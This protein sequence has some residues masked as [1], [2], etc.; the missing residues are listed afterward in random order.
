MKAIVC[1][2]HGGIDKLVYDDVVE[3][4][5]G[6]GEVVVTVKIAGLNFFDTL[7]IAG[8]YQYKPPL[9]FSPGAEGAGVICAVGEGVSDFRVGDRVAAFLNNF[10]REKTAVPV[11]R[12]LPIPADITDEEAAALVVTYG[13]SLHAL[14]DRASLQ[15]GETLAVLGATGGAGLAAVELGKA[16]GARVIAC[17]SSTKKEELAKKHGADA[18]IDYSRDNL[19]D[20]LRN[21]TDGKGVNVVFDPVG[22]DFS[23][24]ALRAMAWGGRFLVV[25][26]ASGT[27]PKISL[28]LPL[29]KSCDIQ[30]VFWTPFLDRNPKKYRANMAQIF[31]WRRERKLSAHVDQIFPLVATAEALSLLTGREAQ[32]KVLVRI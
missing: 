6:P 14:K 28:N 3:P 7:M 16:M 30:G 17:V 22:G 19:K 4:T 2:E 18:T 13:M 1:R 11:G 23:E 21:L 29:L 9:P 31:S 20:A 10:C 15:V 12:L 25:G 24:P 26:F 8:K 27:I 5:A 32:G